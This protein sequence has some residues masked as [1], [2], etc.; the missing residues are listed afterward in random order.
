MGWARNTYANTNNKRARKM[1]A[2]MPMRGRKDG[3]DEPLVGSDP[4]EHYNENPMGDS[5]RGDSDSVHDWITASTL[6]PWNGDGSNRPEAGERS[7]QFVGTPVPLQFA[8]QVAA[9]RLQ[10]RLMMQSRPTSDS[11]VGADNDGGVVSSSAGDPMT[12]ASATLSLA[13]GAFERS[14]LAP[15]SSAGVMQAKLRRAFHP[16]RGKKWA[17]NDGMISLDQV[18]AEMALARNNG[19][20]M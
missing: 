20:D 19:L 8:N 9:H 5:N 14:N 10:Q 1:S 7:H 3:R 15:G 6:S 16:M 17:S 18:A 12:S 11:I 4:I 13:P 2:F